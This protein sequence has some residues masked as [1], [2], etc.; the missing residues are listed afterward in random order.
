MLEYGSSQ[1]P[2]TV[3]G[4]IGILTVAGVTC[5]LVLCAFKLI[6]CQNGCTSGLNNI[7]KVKMNE[8]VQENPK[9]QFQESRLVTPKL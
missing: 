7:I 8:Y 2:G 5:F 9:Q 6:V 4:V 3:P 1:L